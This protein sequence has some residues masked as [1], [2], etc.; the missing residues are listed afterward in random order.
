[1]LDARS[2]AWLMTILAR[3]PGARRGVAVPQ[4]EVRLSRMKDAGFSIET[5]GDADAD[6]GTTHAAIPRAPD[7]RR[8]CDSK[9][10]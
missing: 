7:W 4:V 1:M 10:A 2:V 3:E 8:P 5:S 6:S 9:T